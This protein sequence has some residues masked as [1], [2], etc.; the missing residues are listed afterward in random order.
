MPIRYQLVDLKESLG[1]WIEMMI[2]IILKNLKSTWQLFLSK[3]QSLYLALTLCA[4]YHSGTTFGRTKLSEMFYD[5]TYIYTAEVFSLFFALY[6]NV[7]IYVYVVLS[8]YPYAAT[9]K[10]HQE[11]G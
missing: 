8:T 10:W 2:I 9:I 6:V 4:I 11:F 3:R 5:G 1:E 7:P